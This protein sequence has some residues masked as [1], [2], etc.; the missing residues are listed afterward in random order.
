MSPVSKTMLILTETLLPTKPPVPMAIPNWQN[1]QLNRTVGANG[2]AVNPLQNF[3]TPST[4]SQGVL[5]QASIASIT[6]NNTYSA[7][8]TIAGGGGLPINPTGDQLLNWG[9]V[10]EGNGSNPSKVT[11]QN[12]PYTQSGYKI[13]A[14]TYDNGPATGTNTFMLPSS[15]SRGRGDVLL[16]YPAKR[17]PGGGHNLLPRQL[18]LRL[19]RGRRCHLQ[20]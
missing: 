8:G 6:A 5:T 13:Y 18:H 1:F 11:I 7:N 14:Y 3:G 2:T 17:H 19:A 20:R 9:G 10:N 15:S 16:H 4:D 12:V